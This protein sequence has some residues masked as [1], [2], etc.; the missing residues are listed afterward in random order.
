MLLHF[1][2][3]ASRSNHYRSALTS[4][5]ESSGANHRVSD[6]IGIFLMVR[7]WTGDGEGEKEVLLE[8]NK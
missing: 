2:R 6:F 1:I 5:W 8:T 4:R 7:G 3:H